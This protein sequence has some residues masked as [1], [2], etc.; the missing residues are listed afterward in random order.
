MATQ[1]DVKVMSFDANGKRT[2]TRTF[3]NLSASV[4]SNNNANAIQLAGRYS[5][6]TN[7]DSTD[8]QL[9]KTD[10]LDLEG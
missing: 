5:A 10:D 4:T 3:K 8:A 7:A 9:I 2:G 1:Y 6:L